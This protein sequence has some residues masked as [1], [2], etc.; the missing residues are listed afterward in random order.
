MADFKLSV[1]QLIGLTVFSSYFSI[2]L[3]L[4]YVIVRSFRIDATSKAQGS[5][6]RSQRITYAVL[7][8]ASFAHTWY[9]MFAFLRW[10]FLDHEH[11]TGVTSTGAPR[12][13][14][15]ADW[16]WDTGLFEQAWNAVCIRPHNWWWSEHLCLFTVSFWT[17]FLLYEGRRR[18]VKHIWAYM[19]FGQLVAISVACNLFF[20]AL[21]LR[22]DPPISRPKTKLP[23]LDTKTVPFLL[24]VSVAI[25]L[26]TILLVPHSVAHNYF[27]FNLLVMH[28]LPFVPLLSSE[29]LLSSAFLRIRLRTLF[30]I[31]AVSAVSARIV[32]TSTLLASLPPSIRSS[33]REVIRFLWEV[34]HS[35]P[36]QSSIGW[37][38]IWATISFLVW[39]VTGSRRTMFGRHLSFFS[40]SGIVSVGVVV[41]ALA[42]R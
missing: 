19:L 8:T 5:G 24:W 23:K 15:I 38:V 14:N 33:P 1:Q 11:A 35:H 25:S 28:S 12:L 40:L 41:I 31:T 26:V 29:A 3:S 2:I 27:L 10:S 20:L 39:A 18:N 30:G 17:V 7:T 21:V 34:L 32:T 36:A 37:D 6:S 13:S 4:F 42:A 22:A 9:Y 16:L